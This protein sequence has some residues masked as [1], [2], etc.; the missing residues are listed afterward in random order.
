MPPPS[1][2]ACRALTK[3][4]LFF[5]DAHLSPE[6]VQSGEFDLSGMLAML[7]AKKDEIGARWIVFDGIDVLLT[8]LQ[9]PDRGDA[10][11][12]PHPRLAGGQ[13]DERHHHGQD[14]GRAVRTR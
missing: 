8:L 9:Q 14:R 12:L 7:K 6:V 13:R 5:L 2:G 10:R 1:T 4:K 11:D 3:S